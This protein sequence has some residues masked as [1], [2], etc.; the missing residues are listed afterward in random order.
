MGEHDHGHTWSTCISDWASHWW[1]NEEITCW[2]ERKLHQQRHVEEY[3]GPVDLSVCRHLVPSDIREYCIP[4][5]WRWF[6][7]D[8]QYHHF[9]L[10]RLLSGNRTVVFFFWVGS[11]ERKIK[12]WSS[13]VDA[14]YF[15]IALFS[16]MHMPFLIIW[17]IRIK[18]HVYQYM[19]T[20]VELKSLLVL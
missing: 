20:F 10:I 16:L 17:C 18:L 2:T 1:L 5:L 8:S 15:K 13:I 19:Y 14:K 11:G 12:L 7:V 4:P 9:Q 6:R 3:H